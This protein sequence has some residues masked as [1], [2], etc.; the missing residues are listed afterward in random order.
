MASL[1]RINLM[2]A[3]LVLGSLFLVS[4]FVYGSVLRP[5]THFLGEPVLEYIV[6]P[7]NISG[8]PFTGGASWVKISTQ[9][10]GWI[11][12]SIVNQSVFFTQKLIL[13]CA[14]MN[15]TLEFYPSGSN[16]TVIEHYN[17]S[18][19]TD[20]L[21]VAWVHG[22]IHNLT[23]GTYNLTFI[24]ETT[25]FLY[26]SHYVETL[27]SLAIE[28]VPPTL[29]S[30]QHTPTSFTCTQSSS[31]ETTHPTT[32]FQSNTL[33]IIES[34]VNRTSAWSL[35][36]SIGAFYVIFLRSWLKRRKK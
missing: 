25:C 19:A 16:L 30:E 32:R 7:C 35:V 33:S 17:T 2:G 34:P 1:K 18:S 21:C 5:P 20:C 23:Y 9:S 12:V 24:L 27:T 6:T 15:L 3:L 36:V 29:T 4:F 11:N 14:P 13:W 8:L 22:A 28:I 10:D 31:A 26:D